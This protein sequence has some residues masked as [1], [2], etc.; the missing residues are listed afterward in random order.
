MEK[1]VPICPLSS[2]IATLTLPNGKTVQ[3]PV[4]EG[5]RGPPMIDIT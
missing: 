4:F 1:T 2:N 3:L 5:T